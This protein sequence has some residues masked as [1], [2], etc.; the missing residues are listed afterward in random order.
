MAMFEYEA[1]IAPKPELHGNVVAYTHDERIISWRATCPKGQDPPAHLPAQLDKITTPVRTR[2]TAECEVHVV[3]AFY[4]P[5]PESQAAFVIDAILSK[6]AE[7]L[8]DQFELEPIRHHPTDRFTDAAPPRAI[9][10]KPRDPPMTDGKIAE[11]I[12]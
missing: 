1:C 6:Q 8:L 11:H 5:L 9:R 3:Y 4:K 2:I 7:E 10:S 12:A